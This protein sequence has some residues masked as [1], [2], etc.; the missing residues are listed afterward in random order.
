MRLDQRRYI[1]LGSH[2]T[3][4]FR[5]LILRG[6]AHLASPDKLTDL[7]YDMADKHGTR[8]TDPALIALAQG[9]FIEP[10]IK[11]G[12]PPGKRPLFVGGMKELKVGNLHIL[13]CN[14]AGKPLRDVVVLHNGQLVLEDRQRKRSALVTKRIAPGLE[15]RQELYQQNQ[16]LAATVKKAAQW[17][18]IGQ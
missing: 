17:R 8:I 15:W 16:Q 1:M 7:A 3:E 2:L 18:L 10:I 5:E 13:M 11:P 14:N 9:P 4:K 12:T 6:Q